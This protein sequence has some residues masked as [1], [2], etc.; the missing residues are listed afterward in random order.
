MVS[1]LEKQAG[2]LHRQI[3]FVYE[4]ELSS[5]SWLDD[6]PKMEKRLD[7]RSLYVASQAI[8]RG[9]LSNQETVLYGRLNKLSLQESS[10]DLLSSQRLSNVP[11]EASS[12]K[13]GGTSVSPFQHAIK[14]YYNSN[15]AQLKKVDQGRDAFGYTG[16]LQMAS[17][18]GELLEKIRFH[19]T[20]LEKE[21]V[22][23][24]SLIHIS[25]PTRPY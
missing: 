17:G 8:M 10:V 20:L 22:Q 15:R 13:R 6:E 21:N 23:R 25:E 24:L 12:I 14:S 16:I 4:P 19:A 7:V 5:G 3:G 18:V 1:N 9:M 11:I 2:F